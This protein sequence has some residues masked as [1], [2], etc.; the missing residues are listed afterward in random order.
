MSGSKKSIDFACFLH[1]IQE[2]IGNIY[3]LINFYY[4]V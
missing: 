3:V 2:N 4:F 1:K